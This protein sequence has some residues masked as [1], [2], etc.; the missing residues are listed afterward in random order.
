MQSNISETVKGT[1]ICFVSV[2]GQN[3]SAKFEDLKKNIFCCSKMF[4]LYKIFFK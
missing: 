3:K 2:N 1:E 4:T